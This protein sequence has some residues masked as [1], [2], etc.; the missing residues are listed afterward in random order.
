MG[1][2]RSYGSL[3][4]LEKFARRHTNIVRL[5]FET[6]ILP[7]QYFLLSYHSPTFRR[8]PGRS[9]FTAP[10]K[11]CYKQENN[12]Y[13]VF[14]FQNRC[15]QNFE[16]NYLWD[17]G[18]RFLHIQNRLGRIQDDVNSFFRFLK[19]CP[20]LRINTSVRGTAMGT[21]WKLEYLWEEIISVM[22]SIFSTLKSCAG[23]CLDDFVHASTYIWCFFTYIFSGWY[24][25]F[26]LQLR[27]HFCWE[28]FLNPPRVLNFYK[29]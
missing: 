10:K 28:V 2:F 20:R 9:I 26:T 27:C 19:R 7:F 5:H 25:S 18:H 4:S 12:K 8:W 1:E 16:R 17:I 21:T 15:R 11:G 23:L 29:W 22:W 6:L 14:E 24:V 3:F 13:L